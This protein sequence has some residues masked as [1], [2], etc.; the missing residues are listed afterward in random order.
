MSRWSRFLWQWFSVL[1]KRRA[2]QWNMSEMKNRFVHV[3]MSF[4]LIFVRKY[5]LQDRNIQ[6]RSTSN[7]RTVNYAASP[8]TMYQGPITIFSLP[9]LIHFRHPYGSL[10]S[11]GPGSSLEDWKWRSSFLSHPRFS[12]M[13]EMAASATKTTVRFRDLL[14]RSH[15]M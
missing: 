11:P 2:F 4:S 8:V 3:V 1:L 9:L 6:Q 15:R 14:S 10:I 12:D 7:I 5:V 13:S